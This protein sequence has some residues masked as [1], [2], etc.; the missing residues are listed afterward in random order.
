M[1]RTTLI[2][3]LALLAVAFDV[4]AA[5]YEEEA[6]PELTQEELEE[7]IPNV[8]LQGGFLVPLPSGKR[9]LTKWNEFEAPLFTIKMG[10]MGIGDFNTFD[11]DAT[12]I[13]Q[14][15]DI[16][17]ETE[18]RAGRL[19]L[20]GSIGKNRKITY[21]YAG[22]YNGLS[23]EPDDSVFRMTDLAFTFP[24]DGIGDLTFGKT[25][26]PIHLQRIMPGDGVLLMERAA[27]DGLVPSRGTG[28]KLDRSTF[29]RRVTWSIGWFN[30]WFVAGENFS[31]SDNQYTARIT[32]LPVWE[33]GGR[34]LVHLGLTAR[35]AEP[36]RGVFRYREP[37]EANTAPDFLDT[38]EIQAKDSRTVGLELGTIYEGWSV[39]GEYLRTDVNS[40][41][42]G[43]PT[44]NGWYL[45]TSYIFT[46]ESRSYSRGGGFFHKVRPFKPM[47][48]EGGGI[49]AWEIV[50][51]Y[52]NTDFNDSNVTGGQFRRWTIGLNWFPT[53]KWRV[54]VNYGQG[55]LDRFGASGDT[56]FLQFRLQWLM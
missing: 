39:Q 32:G 3:F 1:F 11:Q 17:S 13:A 24:I 8:A 27:M 21:F 6:E 54:G 36:K 7:E 15:G 9:G 18:L 31:E 16:P 4:R 2:G 20:R 51:R 48:R 46:G 38:G 33:D 44:F 53:N 40:E 14:V 26:E 29:N 25:K 41:V 19:M 28:F 12:S 42:A 47:G 43:D 34:K 22:E 23:R 35:Y 37:P 5:E 10:L 45:A 50:F 55:T 49:G 30:D 52:S 56:N